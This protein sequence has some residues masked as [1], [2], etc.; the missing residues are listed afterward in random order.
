MRFLMLE[1][2]PV[3]RLMGFNFWLDN[4][5]QNT[6]SMENNKVVIERLFSITTQQLWSIWNQPKFVKNWFGSDPKGRVLSAAIDLSVG[7]SYKISFQDSDGGMHTAFGTYLEIIEP[8]YLRYTWEWESEPDHVSELKLELIPQGEKTLL[9]LSHSNLNPNSLH[10]Y[11]EG[12]NRT[13]D[14]IVLLL[15]EL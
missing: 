2:E 3:L 15:E 9:V 12:W 14:K 5:I 1:N 4:I 7:G 6:R 10:G 13:L 11:L 8:T